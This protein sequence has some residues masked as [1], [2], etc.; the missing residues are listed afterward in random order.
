MR[1]G[2]VLRGSLQSCFFC[3]VFT[4][5]DGKAADRNS[6]KCEHP[7]VSRTST[8]HTVYNTIQWLKRLFQLAANALKHSFWCLVS[9]TFW[10]QWP[11]CERA[12]APQHTYLSTDLPLRD[13]DP[14]LT[15]LCK[16]AICSC[17]NS[18]LDSFIIHFAHFRVNESL[19][20][21][22]GFYRPSRHIGHFGDESFQAIDCTCTDNEKQGNKKH[23]IHLNTKEKPKTCPR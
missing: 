14:P 7:L 5:L 19:N 3:F 4:V 9:N 1:V 22:V 8:I 13:L 15:R 11:F 20:E 6:S 17:D 16:V 18:R 23:H 12:T 2:L 21:W 10:T